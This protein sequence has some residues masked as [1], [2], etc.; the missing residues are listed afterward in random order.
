MNLERTHYG[1]VAKTAERYVRAD[2]RKAIRSEQSLRGECGQLFGR[3]II[4]QF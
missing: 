3:R 1:G 2:D 4:W